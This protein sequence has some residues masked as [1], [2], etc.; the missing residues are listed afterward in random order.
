[1]AT[2]YT[3][4]FDLCL[5]AIEQVALAQWQHQPPISERTELNRGHGRNP[6]E[7]LTKACR[8]EDDFG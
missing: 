3:K 4:S 2:F 6:R 1:M 8:I 7:I 5:N